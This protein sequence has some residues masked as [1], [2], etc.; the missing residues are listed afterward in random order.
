MFAQGTVVFNNRIT[1]T[2]ITHVYMGGSSQ[3]SGNGNTDFP[4]GTTDWGSGFVPL[5]GNAY[6][7]ALLAGPTAGALLQ[8][9]PVTTFRTGTGAG[10]IAGT[11][12]TLEGV[13]ADAPSAFIQ[14]VAWDNAGGTITSWDAAQ[15]AWQ[16]G[17]IAAGASPVFQVQS[18]GGDFNVP[19][20]LVGLES[21]NIYMVPEP[22]TFALVGLGAAAMLI[23]RR[24]K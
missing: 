15:A 1:G 14:M 2:L 8:A 6:S 10:F 21:F 20:A 11:T 9:N 17:T 18:I 22:G 13:A 23:F 4:A 19:P 7:T 3:L 16:A 12:A 5:A 24:R